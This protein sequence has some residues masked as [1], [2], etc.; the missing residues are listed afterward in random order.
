VLFQHR[1]LDILTASTLPPPTRV[2]EDYY[3]G[4]WLNST[5][6]SPKADEV[7]LRLLIHAVDCMFERASRT[8]EHTHYRL[9]C[10]LQTY[11]QRH[12]RPVAFRALGPR[13]SEAGYVSILKQF[14]CYVFRV[15]A[16]PETI[17]NS[18]YGLNFQPNE[19]GQMEYI[20]STLLEELSETQSDINKAQNFEIE[21]DLVYATRVN[22]SSEE[23]EEEEE[24]D[25][26]HDDD[27]GDGTDLDS[28]SEGC[29]EEDIN[30][31]I[32]KERNPNEQSHPNLDFTLPEETGKYNNDLC[33]L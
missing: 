5:V 23:E 16:T 14:I 4:R 10:W 18:I 1:P 19:A 26:D 22:C 24:D 6:M 27:D 2:T 21:T 8:L 13:A 33:R 31:L 30:S 9:R 7:K 28:G 17:R 29:F 32:D 11:H 3:L 25:D 12:F 20:W 15:W